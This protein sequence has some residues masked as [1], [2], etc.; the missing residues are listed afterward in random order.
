M[1]VNSAERHST[2]PLAGP[3]KRLAT[4]QMLTQHA[5]LVKQSVGDIHQRERGVHLRLGDLLRCRRPVFSRA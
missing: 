1:S 5:E 3:R 4:G 2:R